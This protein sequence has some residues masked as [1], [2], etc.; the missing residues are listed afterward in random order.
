MGKMKSLPGFFKAADIVADRQYI[1]SQFPKK[2]NEELVWALRT[3]LEAE[4]FSLAT[5]SEAQ[6]ILFK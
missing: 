3:E 2:N 5:A 6:E 4:G 1:A